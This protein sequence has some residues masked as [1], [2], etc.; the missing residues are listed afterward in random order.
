MIRG[1]CACVFVKE[2][3]FSSTHEWVETCG[4]HSQKERELAEATKLSQEIHDY[5]KKRDDEKHGLIG[6][7]RCIFDH[8]LRDIKVPR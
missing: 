4:Y 6:N 2:H 5:L 1:H 8:V 3:E 7:L